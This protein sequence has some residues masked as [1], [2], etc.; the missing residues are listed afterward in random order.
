MKGRLPVY[1]TRLRAVVTIAAL[2]AAVL[3]VFESPPVAATSGILTKSLTG[4]VVHVQ[5]KAGARALPSL[6]GGVL[7][8][9]IATKQAQQAAG[10]NLA[11]S[12]SGSV[13][14]GSLGI[15]TSS[16]GCTARNPDGSVRVNQD[17]TFRRQAEEIIKV[18]PMN[19]SN[20][21][22]GQNDSRIGFNKC[23]FDYSLNGGRTWG[24]GL[25]PF[26]QR[27]NAPQNDVA[28]SGGN[29]NQNTILGDVGT[30]HTYDAFS[31][32][33]LAFD[34][35]GRA[36]F[37]CLG[38]DIASNASGLLVTASPPGVGGSFYNNVGTSNAR[39]YVVVEDNSPNVF[40][41]KNFITADA[42]AGSP[43]RDNVY[44]TWTVFKVDPANPF[45]P[46][47]GG[48]S[49]I[50][51]SMST[52][53]GRTWSTPQEI[54]GSAAVCFGFPAFTVPGAPC[55]FDQGSDPMVSG[56]NGALVVT[57]NNGNTASTNPNGQQLSV[58]C[59]PSGS[60]TNGSAHLNCAQAVRVGPDVIAGE[61]QCDFGRGPEECIPGA[62][63]RTNDFPRIA[64]NR[65]NGHL[66]VTWQDY[67][68]GRFDIHLAESTDGGLH[69]TDAG[70][71][72]NPDSSKD[73]Y[74]P[75]IDVVASSQGDSQK[76]SGNGDNGGNGDH[77]GVSYFRTDRVPNENTT[78]AGG[79]TPGQPGVQAELSDYALAGGLGLNTPYK[80]KVV[81]PQFQ[82]PDGGQAG[83]NG[84]YSGLVLVGT[85]AH[86]IWSD[87]RNKSPFTGP[88]SQGVVRD[89]DIFT[90]ST[91]LPGGGGGG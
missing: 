53:H 10:A 21:I 65:D 17:C 3:V 91:S 62:F 81:S 80:F 49:P 45:C 39:P 75:A 44:V 15:G 42:F 14:A 58:R 59:Q 37:S 47:P 73:H 87:T 54:S 11:P 1:L 8:A 52:D 12:V 35:Q 40:H 56:S 68:T 22:A 77:V 74:F 90:I 83:F 67:S 2:V 23:G 33:A 13:S 16:L 79:F 50:Y 84:D 32:P 29:P 34:S 66:F 9:A 70:P 85:T 46:P 26:A 76:Q 19:P 5:T 72:V 18:N 86:P 4:P 78:P 60:S 31:D 41:D 6:S 89:E 71:A 57:F 61:P 27:L 51:G 43:N 20:L 48:C 25:P 64:V 36:F 55:N 24:D 69:W 28:G 7:E 82:P 63:I 38:F 30:G 88:D